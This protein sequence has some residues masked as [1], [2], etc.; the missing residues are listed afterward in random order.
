MPRPSLLLL[1]V[2]YLVF[3]G[4]SDRVS[5]QRNLIDIPTPDPVA[6]LAAMRLEPAVA[7]NLFAADPQFSKPI[8]TNF[9]SLGRLWVA[10][11]EAY[12]QLAPG[13]IA[14][15]K[16]VVLEDRDGDGV[17]ES[18]TIFAD[19][20]LM[21]TGVVPA[22]TQAAYVAH[23]TELL[24]L[25]DTDGDG[26]A[27]R[28]QVILSGFGTEDTHHL[29][30]TLRWGPDGCLYFNQS[31]YIHSTIETAYGVRR[32]DGGGIWRY[33]PETGELEVF[34]KGF[35]NPWGHVF[36]AYGQS[37]ATDGAYVEGINHAFPDAVFVTSP[38][39]PRWLKGMNPGSPKHCGLVVLS[40]SHVPDD[41]QGDLVT[42]DFRGHRVC[43]FTIQP[44]GSTYQSR[45]QPEIITTS[46]V[47]FRPI[48]AVMG[49]DGALY[50]ADWYNPI[51]QHGEVDFRDDRR[52][53]EHGRI[54]RV[55]FAD[56]PLA[57]RPNYAELPTEA[58]VALLE[59]P[60]LDVRQFARLEL[61]TRDAA[62]V[63]TATAAFVAQADSDSQ[64][65]HRQLEAMWIDECLNHVD[66]AR[67]EAVFNASVA[68]IRAAATR[69]IGVRRSQLSAADAWLAKAV[70][71]PDGLVRLEAVAALGR[72]ESASD[73][74][75][76]L[77]VLD[78]APLD[79][80]LDF[81]LWNA[82]RQLAPRWSSELAAGNFDFAEKTER[83][84]FLLSAAGSP[85]A[86]EPVVQAVIAADGP[87]QLTAEQAA[88]L[89]TPLAGIASPDQ[90][91]RLTRAIFAA[92][93]WQPEQQARL[94][95]SLVA[96]AARRG[97]VPAEAESVIRERFTPDAVDALK[98]A[99]VQ[100]AASWKLAGMVEPIRQQLS[101]GEATAASLPLRSAMINALGQI[102][103]PPA[104]NV[105]QR[106]ADDADVTAGLRADAVVALIGPARKIS[107]VKLGELLSDDQT[108]RSMIDRTAAAL[109]RKGLAEPMTAM[110]S[111]IQLPA[112]DARQMV[113]LARS[114]AAPESL[115]EAIRRA[116]NLDEASWKWSAELS[117]Q[118][119][120]LARDEGSA[121]R[122]EAIYRREAMQCIQCHGIGDGGG[123]V[124]PNL[125]SLG[126]AA[127]PDYILRSLI[128][129]DD[130][131]KEGYT[132]SQ[133]LTLDGRLIQGIAAGG[134]AETLQLRT[135]EGKIVSIAKNEIEE[136]TAGKS[137]MPAGLVDSLTLAEL[138]DL[139]RFLSELGRTP[140]YTVST[141][142]L[143]RSVETLLYSPDANRILNRNSNDSV[144]SSDPAFQWKELTSRVNGSLPVSEMNTYKPHGPVPPTAFVRFMITTGEAGKS[145]LK[146]SAKEGL[147][148]W[149][150]GKPTPLWQAEALAL[151]PGQH[152]ITL[153]IDTSAISDSLTIELLE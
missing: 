125:L 153:G 41:W 48:D 5:A 2:F 16:I 61:K 117:D 91:G 22:G 135:A 90:L 131:L 43:R 109:Q 34:C 88:E 126:G 130:K 99:L 18:S 123:L 66:P 89:I 105:L 102:A 104:I 138:A 40:G 15:D 42:N 107:L 85:E 54:W 151:P 77:R 60:S 27:D 26:R 4:S 150:D 50:I 95:K 9:D 23:A 132:T 64:R 55:T 139:T 152:R 136:E 21:P 36:N 149:V 140:A 75:V 127:T 122:G 49:S 115:I 70:S 78:Q 6:E 119:L 52:D 148:M 145:V 121:E 10:S 30:H 92:R 124:G 134:D 74:E 19:G 141:K 142:Q 106:L 33:R 118:V 76:A 57:N 47:A 67:I 144:T 17:A 56:R 65:E 146:F 8:Q 110:L 116:G 31:I 111:S 147:Q 133:V 32:L 101:A 84:V 29:I 97:M 7:V 98:S 11:S 20:L 108:R 137:L 82:A 120:R 129:P 81:A 14:N 87:I 25:E 44:A 79:D 3:Y 63:R 80:H 12:P 53:R 143:V 71:D 59:D 93:D 68:Q 37:L 86:A 39:A 45:Q 114:A 46:H 72:G 62:E 113:T 128:E 83:L 73:M 28:R 96:Q 69:T 112:D 1:V 103:T 35:V 38:G 13:Q 58:V 24:Y 51:I 100:A 94:L